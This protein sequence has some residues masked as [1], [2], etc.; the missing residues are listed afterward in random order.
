MLIL[1]LP[2]VLKDSLRTFFKV[3]VL[4]LGG[5]VLVLI[6]VLGGQVQE[7]LVLVLVLGGQVLPRQQKFGAMNGA[8][9]ASPI[10][11]EIGYAHWPQLGTHFIT[12]LSTNSTIN[13][14]T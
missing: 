4:V 8:H 1:V 6:L 9:L 14:D 5:Q 13:L 12:L 3:L 2:L 7:V 10:R 11:G